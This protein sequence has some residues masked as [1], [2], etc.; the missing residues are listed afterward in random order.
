M[1]ES[2]TYDAI[3]QRMLDR[4]PADVDKREGSVIYDALAPAAVEMAQMYAEL[5]INYNLSFADT[6]TGDYLSRRTA[7]HGVN[8]KAATAA[9]RLGL[10]FASGDVPLDVPIGTRLSASGVNY[11]VTERLEAGRYELA[12]EAAG[13]IGNQYFGALL[14]IDYVPD[15][16]RAELS[17]IRVPGQEEETDE[18][19]RARFMT[20][21]NEQPFG[22]NVADY[23]QMVGGLDGVGGV[24]VFPA[25]QGGGTVKCTIIDSGYNAP[26]SGLVD[27][28]QTV[29]DP[30]VNAGQ[31]A[32][33]APIGH[34]V[35]IAGVTAV[36]IDATTTLTLST[37]YTLGQV[38][39]DIKAAIEA[40]LLSLRQSW[41]SNSGLI[42][43]VAQLESRVL[44][45]EGVAD[46]SGTTLNGVAANAELRAE[47]IPV[48]GTVTL[49]E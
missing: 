33:Y 3:L 8:R 46:I 41:A 43:R 13:M 15:L 40:Y 42:V 23:L 5:G 17:D 25:W 49:H 29:I 18:A 16:A 39:E 36:P 19:L 7:E 12:C 35:T 48:I 37:G 20:A 10:F 28:V 21:I 6:A 26:T 1:Y 11:A 14:P 31:G 30:V 34:S 22:G 38:E 47:E 2:Q 45:V 24:K 4:V 9:R 32:G 44:G 27:E